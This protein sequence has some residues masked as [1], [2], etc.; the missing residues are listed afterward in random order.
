MLVRR[1][2][3]GGTEKYILTLS[4]NIISKGIPVGVAAK[5][6]PLASSFKRAGITVHYLSSRKKTLMNRVSTLSSIIAKGKY[7]AVHAHDSS[8]F[9]QAATLSSHTKVPLIASVHGIYHKRSTLLKVARTSNRLIAVSPRLKNWLVKLRIPAKKIRM[10][11]NGIDTKI[12]HPASNKYKYKYRKAL[13]LPRHAQIVVY[14]GRFSPDKYSIAKKVILAAK[15]VAASSPNFIVVL[16][17]PR[18]RQPRLLRLAAQV[19][20]RLGRHVVWIRPPLTNIQ[21]AYYAADVIVGT[22]RVALEAMGCGRPVVAAGIAG[23]CGIMRPRNITRS[24]QCHF[25]DHGAF[26]PISVRRLS[27][28][29]KRILH[30]P[31]QARVLGKFGAATVKRKFSISKVGSRISHIYREVTSL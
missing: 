18:S 19:N 9:L 24:I 15:H 3:I 21:H 6:G 17:G 20:R 11:P 2:S 8:S 30:H 22:G 27:T 13:H 5:R 1:L 28:D 29:L 16:Y 4:R 12:F 7:N 25:G 31:A 10:I 14:A 23:Y 26:V